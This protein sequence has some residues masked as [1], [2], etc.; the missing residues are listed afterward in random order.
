MYVSRPQWFPL[1]SHIPACPVVGDVKF[2]HLFKVMPASVA[3][4]KRT[5][6]SLLSDLELIL[7]ERVIICMYFCIL[8][9]FSILWSVILFIMVLGSST[10]GQVKPFWAGFCAFLCVH[11]NV[12]ILPSS[13]T[14]R[15]SKLTLHFP[16]PRPG[17]SHFPRSRGSFSWGNDI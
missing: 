15:Y 14:T 13:G 17:T 3:I 5:C 16:L 7:W 10:F 6:L 12:W 4:L 2:E 8:L 11:I 9:K 1:G